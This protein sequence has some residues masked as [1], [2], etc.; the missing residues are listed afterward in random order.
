[1]VD[2]LLEMLFL[3]IVWGEAGE[4]SFIK[5]VKIPNESQALRRHQQH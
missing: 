4:G 3:I 1:M 2:A 5:Y